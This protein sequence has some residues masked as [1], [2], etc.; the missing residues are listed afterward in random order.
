[1]VIELEAYQIFM[2]LVAIIGASVGM[3]KMLGNQIKSNLDQN[4]EATNSKIG[5]VATQAAKGQEEVRMLEI[6]FLEFKADMPHRY[7]AREDYIRNQTVIESK[8]DA[9]ALKVEN[10]QIKQ[11][12]SNG[13]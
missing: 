7:V 8:L 9:I 5:D 1:M 2:I 13:K 6:K 12:A 10:I 4:F 11:G 3:V